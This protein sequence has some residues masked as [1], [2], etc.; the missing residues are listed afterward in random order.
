MRTSQKE[1]PVVDHAGYPHGLMTRDILIPAL[2]Q[3]G[4][5]EPVESFMLAK[6]PTIRTHAPLDDG[7]KLLI[8]T[9]APALFVL[10][11]AGHLIG[12]LTS[13]ISAKW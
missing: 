12:L 10:D 3:G 6:V 5:R 13:G 8:E 1:F 2:A 9:R 11:R 7:M 4:S